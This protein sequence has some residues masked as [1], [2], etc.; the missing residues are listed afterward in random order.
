M[1][2]TQMDGRTIIPKSYF[3]NLNSFGLS[4]NDN[5]ICISVEYP[6]MTVE[7]V[8]DRTDFS[9]IAKTSRRS[10]R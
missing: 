6:A 3:E 8:I 1:T 2:T 5:P 10:R 7:E 9:A 4:G